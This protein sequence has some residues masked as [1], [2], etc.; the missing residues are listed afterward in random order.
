M[1]GSRPFLDGGHD[2][3]LS[4][5]TTS[6]VDASAPGGDD[7]F[8]KHQRGS[9]GSVGNFSQD[10]LS[11]TGSDTIDLMGSF[12]L[13]QLLSYVLNRWAQFGIAMFT[14]YSEF[15]SNSFDLRSHSRRSKRHQPPQKHDSDAF[16]L[17]GWRHHPASGQRIRGKQRARSASECWN[18]PLFYAYA[19]LQ[20]KTATSVCQ[21]GKKNEIAHAKSS[22]NEATGCIPPNSDDLFE[23]DL[24]PGNRRSSRIKSHNTQSEYLSPP[25]ANHVHI[26]RKA[27]SFTRRWLHGSNARIRRRLRYWSQNTP[28]SAKGQV[29]KLPDLQTSSV[30]RRSIDLQDFSRFWTPSCRSI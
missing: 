14:F 4:Q 27:L 7:S 20:H 6:I 21:T 22:Q 16:R 1:K 19:Q 24:S 18:F 28:T 29:S 5:A 3:C 9:Q 12:I 17:H 11:L 2:A 30:L 15:L 10:K 25:I 26:R 23:R 13:C 8:R